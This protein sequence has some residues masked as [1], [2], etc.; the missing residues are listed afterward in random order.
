MLCWVWEMRDDEN[1]VDRN[2]RE[3]KRL[4]HDGRKR[5]RTSHSFYH[6]NL[7]STGRE[8]LL[9]TAYS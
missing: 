1:N 5:Q 4:T 8:L 9:V 2:R 3:R 6:L 7:A